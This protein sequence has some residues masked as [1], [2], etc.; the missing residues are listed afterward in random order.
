[1]AGEDKQRLNGHWLGLAYYYSLTLVVSLC[2][3]LYYREHN[4]PTTLHGKLSPYSFLAAILSA[5]QL[6][7]PYDYQP[8]L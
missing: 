6:D 8:P 4:K 2:W 1:M 3:S 5:D 7:Q